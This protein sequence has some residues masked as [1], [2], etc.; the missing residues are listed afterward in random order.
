[1]GRGVS[2]STPNPPIVDAGELQ[3]EGPRMHPLPTQHLPSAASKTKAGV[4]WTTGLT[5]QSTACAPNRAASKASCGSV[6][7]R[8]VSAA[9]TKWPFLPVNSFMH[10]FAFWS[11]TQNHVVS[12]EDRRE[13]RQPEDHTTVPWQGPCPLAWLEKHINPH[14]SW[15]PSLVPWC[16]PPTQGWLWHCQQRPGI[17]AAWTPFFPRSHSGVWESRQPV[18]IWDGDL[19][20]SPTAAACQPPPGPRKL[21]QATRAKMMPLSASQT[22]FTSLCHKLSDFFFHYPQRLPGWAKSHMCNANETSSRNKR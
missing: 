7:M 18:H 10:T 6:P 22:W 15:I 12:R 4:R 11:A 1:M 14:I 16:L 3:R 8:K 2:S 17:S 9:T 21:L 20:A 13:H 5:Q 19:H